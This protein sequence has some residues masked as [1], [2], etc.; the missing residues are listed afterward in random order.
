MKNYIF[1]SL[2]MKS[3]DLHRGGD[4]KRDDRLILHGNEKCGV[5]NKK[6][7]KLAKQGENK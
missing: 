7:V 2:K 4:R 6:T 3:L 1:N 5:L